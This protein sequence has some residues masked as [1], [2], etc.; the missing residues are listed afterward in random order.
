LAGAMVDVIDAALPQQ[1]YRVVLAE[2]G[3]PDA[4]LAW[5]SNEDGG[6]VRYDSEPQASL[7]RRF[8]VWFLSL[9]PIES[10][11]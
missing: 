6:E 7:W 8:G 10:Q 4:R 2:A 1:A 3:T 9:L 11:L 5:V